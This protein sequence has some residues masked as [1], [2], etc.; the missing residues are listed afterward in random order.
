[1]NHLF[2][3]PA[4]LLR[5]PRLQAMPRRPVLLAG[6]LLAL[7]F[8]HARS[9]PGRRMAAALSVLRCVRP[10]AR[11]R[12]PCSARQSRASLQPLCAVQRGRG[13]GFPHATPAHF[14]A[15][16]GCEKQGE[17]DLQR[18][19]VV[20]QP[21]AC[22]SDPRLPRPTRRGGPHHAGYD[23]PEELLLRRTQCAAECVWRGRSPRRSRNAR[24]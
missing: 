6:A 5:R 7:Q 13:P 3:S 24:W 23:I 10:P 16:A 18:E 1:V 15:G 14:A 21:S 17:H 20:G 19:T 9:V 12:L 11:L 4:A 8:R 2:V 22:R